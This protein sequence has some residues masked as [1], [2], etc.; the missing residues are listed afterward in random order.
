MADI[1][2]LSS[3]FQGAALSAPTYHELI[4]NYPAVELLP[5]GTTPYL[6]APKDL[7]HRDKPTVK[8]CLPQPDD[9]D[10]FQ[11]IK[12][13]RGLQ[14]ASQ[15]PDGPQ[16]E[17][18]LAAV[19][20]LGRV[21]GHSHLDV[22]AFADAFGELVYRSRLSTNW[23]L[24]SG[25]VTEIKEQHYGEV[26][27]TTFLALG[28]DEGWIEL[29]RNLL[30]RA[31]V[32][33]HFHVVSNLSRYDKDF[34][35]SE[36]ARWDAQW[37]SFELPTRKELL[38]RRLSTVHFDGGGGTFSIPITDLD[39][40]APD[41]RLWTLL[42]CGHEHEVEASVLQQA[43]ATQSILFACPECGRRVLRHA[44]QRL[45]RLE[46]EKESQRS[47]FRLQRSIVVWDNVA[48]GGRVATVTGAALLQA[49]ETILRCMD[50]PESV[51]P[52][53]LRQS[54]FPEVVAVLAAFRAALGNG[55]AAEAEIAMTRR[56]M[57][58][59]LK[60]LADSTLG[61][62]TH[63]G[64][65]VSPRYGRMYCKWLARAVH[66]AVCSKRMGEREEVD[67]MAVLME[68]MKLPPG[69]EEDGP[70]E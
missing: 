67:G 36:D 5:A 18:L 59:G 40:H 6:A 47:H 23:Q 3:I 39:E 49:L 54:V 34:A 51:M 14:T 33:A 29:L 37:A 24:S 30:Q 62:G 28:K 55:G 41:V 4:I 12:V 56:A 25:K 32:R 8:E 17:C 53:S 66:Y 15:V 26:E 11:L 35:N 44:D 46:Q 16:P 13:E 38:C 58:D 68:G 45:V 64:G 31:S 2:A 65:V 9:V 57:Y 10:F 63:S 43:T 7:R 19:S 69:A 21:T 42:P 60:G 48:E 70:T 1:A 61:C 22:V 50:P 52:K 27:F 20:R